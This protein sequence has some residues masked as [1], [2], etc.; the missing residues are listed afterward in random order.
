MFAEDYN[1]QS[2][3]LKKTYFAFYQ[4]HICQDKYPAGYP[5]SGPNRIS[6]TGIRLLD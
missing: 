4:K 5:V 1:R 2:F 6:G 3:F